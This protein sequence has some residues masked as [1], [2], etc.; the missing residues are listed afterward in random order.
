MIHVNTPLG[1]GTVSRDM[2]TATANQDIVSVRLSWGSANLRKEVLSDAVCVNLVCFA[3][4]IS[5]GKPIPIGPIPLSTTALTLHQLAA[6]KFG[7]IDESGL[8]LAFRGQEII[9]D[10]RKLVDLQIPKSASILCITAEDPLST[11]RFVI[12]R[13]GNLLCH[14]EILS[15]AFKMSS[16]FPKWETNLIRCRDFKSLASCLDRVESF[17]PQKVMTLGWTKI[18]LAWTRRVKHVRTLPELCALTWAFYDNIKSVY[19]GTIALDQ[20]FM[21]KLGSLAVTDRHGQITM[22]QALLLS[23]EDSMKTSLFEPESWLDLSPLREAWLA[24]ILQNYHLGQEVSNL[25]TNWQFLISQAKTL[26]WAGIL[27]PIRLSEAAEEIQSFLDGIDSD[28]IKKSWNTRKEIW[29]EVLNQ[30]IAHECRDFPPPSKTIFDS[31][32]ITYGDS[33]P[34]DSVLKDDSGD[35]RLPLLFTFDRQKESLRLLDSLLEHA[36]MGSMTSED[37]LDIAASLH[38]EQDYE[39]EYWQEHVE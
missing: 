19:E 1:P 11:T 36:K 2:L 39:D 26:S 5:K 23:F 15:S 28:H 33:T 20:K 9:K 21:K 31:F 10:S 27:D 6:D 22:L 37:M 25:I 38:M 35:S 14:S 4:P 29:I 13:I 16:R 18:R 30:I 3:D 34:Q 24:K 32:R 7:V 8:R 17:F 12:R